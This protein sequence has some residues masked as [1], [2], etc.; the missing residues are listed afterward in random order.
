MLPRIRSASAMLLAALALPA[1]LSAAPTF[2]VTFNDPGATYS[3]YYAD[4]TACMIAAGNFWGPFI[5]SNASIEIVVAFDPFIPTANGRSAVSS[6]LYTQ[7]GFNVFEQGVAA[8]LRTGVDVNGAAPDVEIN[9]GVGYLTSQ[10]WFDPAPSVRTAPIPPFR[11][12][13]VSVFIHEIGHAI[14]YNGW[15]NAFDGSYPGDYRSPF[16]EDI[17]FDGS[18]F[19][20][21]DIATSL[22]YG[23]QPPLTYGNVNHW[24]NNDPRPGAGLIPQ[25][26]NGVVYYFQ[27]RYVI[28][29]LDI[30]VLFDVGVPLTISPC[31][32]D[33]NFSGAADFSDVT[34]ILSSWST[35]NA[36]ADADFDGFV[37]FSDVT[38]V[39][40]A[41]GS[42]C[43]TLRPA[44]LPPVAL[45]LD[46]AP[47]AP[48]PLASHAT[49]QR[50]S[51]GR[52]LFSP[53]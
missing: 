20:Q 23:G 22:V 34:R 8:E 33:L 29:Q 52:I 17:A 12:D 9:I 51:E 15:I 3:A 37:S 28:T 26:M 30:A 10:L 1:T 5:D 39:L 50:S 41:W 4:I 27:R 40:S 2:S 13:A 44:G 32:A 16:D 7:G 31:R 38:T 49:L 47:A 11:V 46:P 6:Y 48:T 43:A 42:T 19:F 53:R 35:D 14:A 36:S 21:T 24:G 25:L 18:D 45:V